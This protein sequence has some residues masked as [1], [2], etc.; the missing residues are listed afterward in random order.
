MSKIL[1]I[2]TGKTQYVEGSLNCV[3]NG[4]Y[5]F[6]SCTNLT[7]FTSDLSSLTDGDYMFEGCSNLT[8]FTS[9]LSSLTNGNYMFSG[10]SNLTSFNGDLS[11]LTDGNN[12]FRNCTYLTSFS[13]DLSSL[14]N[15]SS[16]FG[17]S[18]YNCTAL[19]LASIENISETI[20]NLNAQGKRGTIHIGMSKTLQSDDSAAPV[21]VALAA[22]RA[23]GWTVTEIYNSTL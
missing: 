4:S 6:R 13:S 16:M 2:N 21:N 11:S 1:L 10:C 7:S 9:D 19:N 15:G 14:T 22:I 18:S 23:K 17:S 12:M 8:S 3:T 20:N 5:M